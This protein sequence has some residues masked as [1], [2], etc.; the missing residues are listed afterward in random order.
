VKRRDLFHIAAGA[1]VAHAAA[2]RKFFTQAE[3]ALA[4]ELTELIIPADDHSGG[5]RT[6]KVAEY[7]DGLLAESFGPEARDTW[8]KGLKRVESLSIEM[9][10][11]S[12]LKSTPT[13][14]VAVVERMS[15]GEPFFAELKSRTIQA[16]YTSKIG[17]H[18]ELGY[19]GNTYQRGDYSGFLPE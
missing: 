3:L 4:D 2:S 16:Y 15:Q 8:R 14:R 6:A 12:F 5:A 1:S 18:D 7:I 9:H 17:I 10:K 11:T 13:E 19:L